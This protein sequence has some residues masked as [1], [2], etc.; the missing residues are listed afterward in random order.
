[1]SGRNSRTRQHRRLFATND[2][3]WLL[4]REAQLQRE[5]NCR[6]CA[7]EG[8]CTPGLHVDHINGRAD[9]REDYEESNLQ[10]LCRSCHSRKTRAQE[11]GRE[12]VARGCDANG[13]PIDAG[14]PW[15]TRH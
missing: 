2:A 9:R 7:S 3:A 4:I 8:R 15:R 11:L 13:V 14:H 12:Y 1:M 6:I 5:P 10:S